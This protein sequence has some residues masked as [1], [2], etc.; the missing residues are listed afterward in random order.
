MPASMLDRVHALA[1][2]ATARARPR[3][4]TP[5]NCPARPVRP[6]RR[7]CPSRGSAHVA[8]MPGDSGGISYM[9]PAC[10]HSWS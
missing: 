1:G 10:G 2:G 7:P 4:G 9:C 5:P 6:A 8:R 3:H